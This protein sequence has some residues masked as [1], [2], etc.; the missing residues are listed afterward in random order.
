MN[1][2]A[3]KIAK[4]AFFLSATVI[5]T[6]TGWVFSWSQVHSRDW[7]G[8][9][10]IVLLLPYAAVNRVFFWFFHSEQLSPSMYHLAFLLGS[11]G[12]ILYYYAI[13]ALVRYMAEMVRQPPRSSPKKGDRPQ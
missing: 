6:V 9:A 13:F 7:K 5:L 3:K 1:P 8:E 11:L 10:G 12:Q 4:A 2:S